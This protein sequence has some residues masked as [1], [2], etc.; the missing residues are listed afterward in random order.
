MSS[1]TDVKTGAFDGVGKGTLT[2]SSSL[3]RELNNEVSASKKRKTDD[4]WVNVGRMQFYL[5]IRKK[6]SKENLTKELKPNAGKILSVKPHDDSANPLAI[7]VGVPG[8][9]HTT[10]WKR[11]GDAF[12]NRF[13]YYGRDSHHTRCEASIDDDVEVLDDP[14]R[15]TWWLVPVNI[16][17]YLHKEIDLFERPDSVVKRQVKQLVKYLRGGTQ[18]NPPKY[19]WPIVHSDIAEECNRNADMVDRLMEKRTAKNWWKEPAKK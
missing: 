16:H 15:K 7:R 5:E 13:L 10:I 17:F 3:K 11:G 18:P 1:P 9:T 19:A 14:K 4:E 12:L 8:R 6:G 2:L